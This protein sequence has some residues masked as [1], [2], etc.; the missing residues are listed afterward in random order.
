MVGLEGE[1]AGAGDVGMVKGMSR[2]DYRALR[3]SHRTT[4][5]V[6]AGM[7]EEA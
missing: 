4:I 6:V 7:E 1:G 3:T 5:A 2:I